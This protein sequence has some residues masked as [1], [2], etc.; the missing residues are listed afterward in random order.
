MAMQGFAPEWL[1]GVLTCGILIAGVRLAWVDLKKLEIELETLAV[2]LGLAV[3]QSWL[4]VDVFETA[5]RLFSGLTF[6]LTLALGNSRIPGLSKFGAG[7]PPLIG[8]IAFLVAPMILPWAMLSAVLMLSTSAFYSIKRG[9]KLFKSM[10][11]AAPPLLVAGMIIYL[12]QWSSG[13]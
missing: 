13:A 8:V 4:F 10:F 1:Y 6:W 12:I 2:M 11:P 5:I 7:D 9:K 3:M